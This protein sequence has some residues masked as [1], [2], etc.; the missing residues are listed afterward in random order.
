M[1]CAAG[2]EVLARVERE[3]WRYVRAGVVFVL[4]AQI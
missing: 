2:R 3:A 4:P 1:G